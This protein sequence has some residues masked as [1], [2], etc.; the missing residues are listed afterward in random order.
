[1]KA[2]AGKQFKGVLCQMREAYSATESALVGSFELRDGEGDLQ[3][4]ACLDMDD[5]AVTHTD[6][7]GKTMVQFHWIPPMGDMGEVNVM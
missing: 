6:S 5:S 1:M 2:D 4:L 3:T 7:T